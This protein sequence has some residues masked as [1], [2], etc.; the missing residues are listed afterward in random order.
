MKTKFAGVEDGE[1][2]LRHD[3][4]R[5]D[6]IDIVAFAHFLEFHIPLGEL[7]RREIEAITLVGDVM[8]LTKHLGVLELR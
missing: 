4:F 6:E 1:G 2:D 7:L 8:I 3:V 5:S